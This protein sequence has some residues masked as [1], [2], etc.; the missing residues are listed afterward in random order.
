V[1]FFLRSRAVLALLCLLLSTRATLASERVTLAPEPDW[2]A[3]HAPVL[4][5][6]VEAD[7]SNGGTRWLLVDHQTRIGDDERS[8]YRHLV[9][10][11]LNEDGVDNL[12]NL[13]FEVDPSYQRFALHRLQVLRNGKVISQD[14]RAEVQVLQRETELEARIL[15]GRQTINVLLHDVRVGDVVEYAY[16]L[17]GAHPAFHGIEFDSHSL[18]WSEPL[19]QLRLRLLAPLSRPLQPRSIGSTLE[20]VVV[21][22][23][24]WREWRWAQDGIG[25]L[26]R[27]DDTPAWFD[28]WPSIAWSEFADWNA[29]ARWA[30]PLYAPA[31]E[32]GE[33]AAV[34][35]ELR[36]AA[37]TPEQRL[38]AALRWVQGEVRYLGIEVGAGA[39]VP[40]QPDLVLQRRFGD[41]KDKTLL[42]LSLLAALDI[43]ADAAL[44]HS[45]RLV[46]GEAL[47]PTPARF[48]HVIVRARLDGRDYWLDPTSAR[49]TAGLDALVQPD[50]GLALVVDPATRELTAM[51]AAMTE[52]RDISVSIDARE[53]MTAAATMQ[54][55][56]IF[57][58][59]GAERVRAQFASDGMAA[60]KKAYLDYYGNYYDGLESAG[61]LEVIDHAPANRFEV[62]EQ[63]TIGEYWAR[64]DGDSG[65]WLAYVQVP[66]ML[67]ALQVPTVAG[68]SMPLAIEHPLEVNVRTE[69]RL[70]EPWPFE[71]Y[72]VDIDDP[73]F[74]FDQRLEGDENHFIFID[75]YRSLADHVPAAAAAAYAERMQDARDEVGYQFSYDPGAA[76][77][78]DALDAATRASGINWLLVLLAGL[79]VMVFGGLAL[80]LALWDPPPRPS[81][82]QPPLVGLGGWLIL[83]GLGLF[84]TP[85]L[86]LFNFSQGLDALSVEGWA[87]LTHP[88]SDGYH[89]LW[90]PLLL[91]EM[92]TVIFVLVFSVL[93]S[94]LF[95]TRRSSL[96]LLYGLFLIVQLLLVLAINAGIVNAGI[97]EL[98][99]DSKDIQD[100]VRGALSTLI[101][102]AYFAVSERVKATFVRR[103]AA[104]A[105]AP[106]P[107]LA[108]SA[109][110]TTA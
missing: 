27:E 95:F 48:N 47:P 44:V 38:L 43:D 55:R 28:P 110:A 72:T 73:H 56:T 61:E 13:S 60:M 85:A 74:R 36:A 6:A 26:Q 65:P 75:E 109:E 81:T 52:R 76:G 107:S 49:Q 15:D 25:S 9:G 90:A 18:Q 71:A 54:I 2:V 57:H 5:V 83:P 64:E 69:V 16:S 41:C 91:L 98:T 63:Y 68:R 10:E 105:S 17:S 45:D 59:P 21:E 29:V 33:L 51:P 3:P 99:L 4:E 62:V 80:L 32:A 11:A 89:P 1:S 46:D 53:G 78:G 106:L 31:P 22:R 20:P 12:A 97:P 108:A 35:A 101:W 66:D 19:A 92:S 93:L 103:R 24:G 67:D 30:A 87:N 34:V 77:L 70:H 104:H 7:R 37:D 100:M 58:G 84:L 102:C 88:G 14:G 50:L 23:N 39:F 40:R 42:L 82:R 96:P 8:D 94:W 79:L 86:T